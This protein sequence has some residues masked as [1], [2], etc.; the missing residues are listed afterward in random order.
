MRKV[1][2]M[3]TS[4]L[5]TFSFRSFLAL[6]SSWMKTCMSCMVNPSRRLSSALMVNRSF[7]VFYPMQ[8]CPSG[9]ERQVKSLHLRRLR[10]YSP[11]LAKRS[12]LPG[13]TSSSLAHLSCIESR[14]PSLG[15][16]N[17]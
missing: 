6:T 7:Q 1:M 12:L 9:L 13:K 3:V 10:L 17:H 11:I 14:R 16:Y 5:V 15:V 2:L 4:T 8:F